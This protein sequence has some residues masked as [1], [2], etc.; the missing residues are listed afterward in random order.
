MCVCVCL[1]VCVCV[2]VCVC[3]LSM[4]VCTDSHLLTD[5]W[6]NDGDSSKQFW[7]SGQGSCLQFEREEQKRAIRPSQ[8]ELRVQAAKC[9]K[10]LLK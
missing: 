7:Q 10:S 4:S 8:P 9:N 2:C 3:M 6:Q 1:C 5:C